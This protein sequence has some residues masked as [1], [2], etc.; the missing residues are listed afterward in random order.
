MKL[1]D[2][3]IFEV[4]VAEH[5]GMCFG[6]KAAIENAEQV[7]LQKPVTILGR[8]AHNPTVQNRMFDLGAQPGELDQ[9]SA[10]TKD[11]LITAHGAS[12]RDRKR[13][14]NA[15]HVVTD[16]T[17]PLVHKAHEALRGLVTAGYSPV[18][19][20][21]QGHVEVKGLT[22]DFPGTCVV[23]EESDIENLPHSDKIGVISQTTQP[24]E[25]A[26]ALVD[27]IKQRFPN[28][29][30]LFIDTVCRPTKERQ[31][32]LIDLCRK[33]E[34]VIVVGGN[35]SNNT[36]KLAE[37]C[38]TLGCISYQIESPNDIEPEWF[39][40]IKKVGVTA[41]TSTPD[42][43]VSRVVTWLE[44]LGTGTTPQASLL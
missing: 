36:R 15:G 8:L 38:Q 30:V 17:C 32:A 9:P 24:L 6:V 16:T 42:E 18:V 27:K 21:K 3:P 37:S 1:I 33:T 5:Y 40:G 43:D 34:L 11:V 22:G 28:A 44:Q 14:K 25:K 4:I 19:I 12:D 10:A 26:E 2:Q 13:W 39:R 20:G 7:A 23:L 31:T 35:H 41:G 29:D